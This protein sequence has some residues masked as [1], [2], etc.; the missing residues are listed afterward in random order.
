MEVSDETER[1]PDRVLLAGGVV[2]SPLAALAFE[3]SLSEAPI[4][5][6]YKVE[7]KKDLYRRR[8]ST[9]AASPISRPCGG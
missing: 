6:V 7:G 9:S 8:I 1:L 2:L 4:D 3:G 5:S